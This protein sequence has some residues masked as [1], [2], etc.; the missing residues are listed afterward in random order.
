MCH[1]FFLLV[2]RHVE[3]DDFDTHLVFVQQMCLSGTKIFWHKPSHKTTNDQLPVQF[4]Y[5][6]NK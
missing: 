2:Y 6:W 5:G 4:L 3:H 1:L